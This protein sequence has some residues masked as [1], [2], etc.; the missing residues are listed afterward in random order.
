[1]DALDRLVKKLEN[2]KLDR[3]PTGILRKL[4]GEGDAEEAG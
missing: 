2:R 3:S 1:M 4:A